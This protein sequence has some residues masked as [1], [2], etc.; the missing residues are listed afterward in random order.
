MNIERG[1]QPVKILLR[2][3]STSHTSVNLLVNL[4]VD[5]C[6]YLQCVQFIIEIVIIYSIYLLLHYTAFGSINA[7]CIL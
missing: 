5:S 3:L 2:L 6:L 1:K 7:E 4:F